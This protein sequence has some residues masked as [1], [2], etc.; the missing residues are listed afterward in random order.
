VPA[1]QLF[2]AL[3]EED[4]VLTPT[5]VIRKHCLDEVGGFDTQFRICE[6]YDMWLRLA[7]RFMLRGVPQ[8]L[9]RVRI[10]GDN[11]LRDTSALVHYRLLVANKHFGAANGDPTTWP[12]DK[13]CAHAFALRDAALVEIQAGQTEAGWN[14]LGRAMLIWPGL[15]DGPRTFYELA[16]G[17]QPRGQRGRVDPLQMQ[18]NAADLLQRMGDLID[19]SP[20]QELKSMRRTAFGNAYVALSMLAEQAGDWHLARSY[21]FKAVWSNPRLGAEPKVVRRLIKTVAGP[22]LA[23]RLRR[24]RDTSTALAHPKEP[25]RQ[26]HGQRT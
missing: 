23:G 24:L 25:A 8:P 14:H 4:F 17:H 6:D 2:S 19:R 20:N 13:Q 3:L 10:H 5:V 7:K 9:V 1:Q 12:L 11:T 22:K 21:A 18:R 16:L 15:L 26:N